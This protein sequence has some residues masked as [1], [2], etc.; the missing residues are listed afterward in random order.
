MAPENEWTREID[1]IIAGCGLSGGVAAIE[2]HDAGSS[3]MVLEKGEYPGGVS[4]LAGGGLRGSQD[5]EA[6]VAYL[7]ETSG[8]RIDEVILRAFAEDLVGLEDYVRKLAKINGAVI[9][10]YGPETT[11]AYP[12]TGKDSFYTFRVVEIPGFDGYP[13]VQRLMAAGVNTMKVVLDNIEARHIDIR[14]STPVKRL[15]R[16]DDGQ[17]AGV[18]AESGGREEKIKARRAVIL[19]CG[20]FEHNE[21]LKK[22]YFQGMPFYSMAPLTHTGD[23]VIMAQKEGAA[24]WHMW[25]IHGSYGYKFDEYPI[26]FRI[27][28]AGPRNPMR[29][30]PWIVVDRYGNRY[31]NECQPAPQD[32]GHRAMELYDAD[33]PGYPRIP[34]YVVF[35]EVG[36]MR[37]PIGKPLSIGKFL[38]DWSKD[39]TEE[40]AKGW[41]LSGQTL[42][43]LAEKITATADNGDK[44]TGAELE[45]SVAAWN[46]VVEQGVDPLSR[47][48]GTMLKIKV[49]PYY[50]A[51]VWP[52]ITNTQGGPVHN[53]KQQVLDSYGQP[54]PRLYA[55]GELSSMWGHLYLLGGNLSEC[56]TS[57]RAAGRWVATETPH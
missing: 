11:G 35:D 55:V 48:E 17:I 6:S 23:G 26:A 38:Y 16:G 30:L 3:V 8:G 19:A 1:V 32:T 45:V 18:I 53:I 22:Q 34:S 50:A 43:E 2:A 44:M 7:K 24:L 46:K 42:A 31:M 5:I 40:L 57:G 37:G 36:R 21:W 29:I 49:P 15:V 20:G 12:F 9:K 56:I 27:P 39:N 52:V 4:M 14:T 47:P 54:I 33:M 13:W 25:H 41:I 10:T 51:P 28:L